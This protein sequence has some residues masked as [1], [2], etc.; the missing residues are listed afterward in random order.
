MEDQKTIE[1]LLETVGSLEHAK[2][3]KL[4]T[5]ESMKSKIRNDKLRFLKENADKF[6]EIKGIISKYGYHYRDSTW[7]LNI[8]G[9][10]KEKYGYNLAVYN[11]N[12]YITNE[13]SGEAY[14]YNFYNGYFKENYMNVLDDIDVYTLVDRAHCKIK[15]ILTREIQ[16][17]KK[18]IEGVDKNIESTSKMVANAVDTDGSIVITVGGTKYKAVKMEG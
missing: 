13:E 11:G 10:D 1:E 7:F 18:F 5:L 8:K 15:E 4:N 12:L 6:T 2:E 16:D 9:T 14:F 3:E 17:N